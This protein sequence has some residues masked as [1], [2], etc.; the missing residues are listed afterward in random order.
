MN[1]YRL[2]LVTAPDMESARKLV[3]GAVERRFAACGKIISN[4]E[5]HYWWEGKVQSNL[6]CQLLYKTH[7]ERIGDLQDWIVSE[8]P[9]ETPEFVVIPL[10]SG[11]EK[12]LD[13][14]KA[15]TRAADA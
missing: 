5:S 8:H 7:N 14:I 2:V 3:K 15:E 13:W 6:E 12:Y 10:E 9:F 1:D 4:I 11:F